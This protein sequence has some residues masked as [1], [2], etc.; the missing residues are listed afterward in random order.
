[1][2]ITEVIWWSYTGFMIVV[3]LFMLVFVARVRDRG[4]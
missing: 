4:D 2:Y 1:M 3:A